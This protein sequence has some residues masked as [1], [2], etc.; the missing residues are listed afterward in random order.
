MENNSA[1]LFHHLLLQNIALMWK[2]VS[3]RTESQERKCREEIYI[4]RDLS[5]I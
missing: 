3:I 2:S 1:Q 4:N 5:I